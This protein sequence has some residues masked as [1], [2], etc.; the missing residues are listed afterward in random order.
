MGGLLRLHTNAILIELDLTCGPN[1]RLFKQNSIID[2]AN[3]LLFPGSWPLKEVFSNP[4]HGDG[5]KVVSIE[6]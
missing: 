4:T 2:G 6:H 1:L 5:L 3:C